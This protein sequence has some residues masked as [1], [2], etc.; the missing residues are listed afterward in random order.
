MCGNEATICRTGGA[1]ATLWNFPTPQPGSIPDPN[2]YLH[3]TVTNFCI[4]NVI[5]CKGSVTMDSRQILQCCNTSYCNNLEEPTTAS[6]SEQ[7]PTTTTAEVV[8]TGNKMTESTSG[9]CVCVWGGGV[10]TCELGEV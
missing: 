2:P 6:P 10:C 3:V 9:K 1:C 4:D 5:S 7:E 8:S